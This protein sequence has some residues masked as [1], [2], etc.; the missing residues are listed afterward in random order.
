VGGGVV[1]GFDLFE[2]SGFAGVV[3]AE[4]QDR[5]FWLRC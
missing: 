2:Q 3:E 1:E 5:V 4:K